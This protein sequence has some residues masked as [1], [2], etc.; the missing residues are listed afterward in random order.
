MTQRKV[1]VLQLVENFSLGGAE[2]IVLTLA[3]KSG[4]ERFEVIPCAIRATGPLE[5]ELKTA[6][7]QYRILGIARRSIL[8]GPFFVADFRRALRALVDTLTE[9]SIDVVHAHL[10]ESSLLAVLAARRA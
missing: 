4:R 10:T 5:E 2:K 6:G 3:M 9:L 1:R 7:I 8:T